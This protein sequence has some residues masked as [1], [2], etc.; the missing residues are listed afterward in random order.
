MAT[1]V[2][3]ILGLLTGQF[4]TWCAD[5]LP[6]ERDLGWHAGCPLCGRPL[7]ADMSAPAR[8]LVLL[9][10]RACPTEGGRWRWRTLAVSA[11]TAAGFGY[12]W[13]LYGWT[14]ELIVKTIYWAVFVL[15]TVIDLEH[16]L[17][18]N[19]IVFPACLLALAGAL[20]TPEPGI[21]RAVLGGI[22]GFLMVYVIY[23]LGALFARVMARR[24]GRPIDE[25]A[26]GAGDVKLTLFIGLVT[27]L[28]GVIFALVIGILLG[29]LFA[30][31]YLLWM[32]L[33]RRRYSAFTAIPYGPFLVIGALVMMLYG[34]A[35]LRWYAR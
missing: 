1:A 30:G 13:S 32:V 14:A 7:P 27:G 11:I 8:W 16:R 22:T 20:L 33:V 35:V 24:R 28:P 4:L 34:P 9:G 3:I 6:A 25:V 29:G 23:L 17:I 26:F 18:L 19:V 15:V 31:A 2:Y 10:W 12:L 5:R 21:R